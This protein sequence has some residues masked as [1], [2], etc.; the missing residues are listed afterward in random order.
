MSVW[1]IERLPPNAAH[2]YLKQDDSTQI[3]YV[4]DVLGLFKGMKLVLTQV[5]DRSVP[6]VQASYGPDINRAF[7]RFW[8]DLFQQATKA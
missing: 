6:A 7:G 3:R 2:S 5:P 8:D 4:T 1:N